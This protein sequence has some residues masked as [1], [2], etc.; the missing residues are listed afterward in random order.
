MKK[1]LLSLP[2]LL[3]L[4]TT[5]AAQLVDTTEAKLIKGWV[6]ARTI[7]ELDGQWSEAPNLPFSP[8]KAGFESYLKGRYGFNILS[9]EGCRGTK[10]RPLAKPTSYGN[11]KYYLWSSYKRYKCEQIF[12]QETDP[13]GTQRC[14]GT[15]Y[16]VES[17]AAG[18]EATSFKW[19]PEKTNHGGETLKNDC[20]WL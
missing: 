17:I 18:R 13:R 12:Y 20:R 7:P 15:N 5:A 11:L 4:A 8:T 1:V 16:F 6:E 14:M 10:Q 9:L 3:L 19:E 2:A